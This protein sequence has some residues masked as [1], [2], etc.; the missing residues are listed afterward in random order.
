MPLEVSRLVE[1]WL[2]I[3]PAPG[4]G[5]VGQV[6]RLGRTGQREVTDEP[7]RLQQIE[8]GG[9][10]VRV[11][12]SRDRRGERDQTIAVAPPVTAVTAATTSPNSGL[13]LSM[14][15]AN[16][17]NTPRFRWISWVRPSWSA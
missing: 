12:R 5:D 1:D 11:V 8:Q 10:S 6:D 4:W 17:P 7:V 14:S 2:T 15:T 13:P 3:V 16:P 9:L